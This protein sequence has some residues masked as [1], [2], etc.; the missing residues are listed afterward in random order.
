MTLGSTSLEPGVGSNSSSITTGTQT[1]FLTQNRS[2]QT[3]Q[4][5]GE[6]ELLQGFTPFKQTTDSAEIDFDPELSGAAKLG[7]SVSD[8][9][10]LVWLVNFFKSWKNQ[11]V[12]PRLRFKK[13]IVN[14]F[15][16]GR[17][18]ELEKRYVVL[19]PHKL[20]TFLEPV[21]HLPAGYG[22]GIRA[23][24]KGFVVYVRYAS[25][26]V[27]TRLTPR[28]RKRLSD[29][30]ERNRGAR[31]KVLRLR[32]Q[33]YRKAAITHA[34]IYYWLFRGD[35][36]V[37]YLY[38]GRS[39]GLKANN[40][41]IDASTGSRRHQEWV[42]LLQDFRANLLSEAA[43]SGFSER[44][45]TV[46]CPLLPRI[47][48]GDFDIYDTHIIETFNDTAPV[49]EVVARETFFIHEFVRTGKIKGLTMAE[50]TEGFVQEGLPVVL[51][52]QNQ[53]PSG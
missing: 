53:L 41:R 17:L 48:Q 13:P 8:F 21:T 34:G 22:P 18:C 40:R 33:D 29:I 3:D 51:L 42:D 15:E 39:A 11:S 16:L 6:T 10:G 25:R 30:R 23:A 31:G 38:I 2:T 26:P 9:I 7:L 37:F 44:L 46:I 1:G 24:P 35:N 32:P 5:V 49:P 14:A 28:E 27:R 12:V 36:G 20:P 50:L 47:L 43:L 52:N 19:S 4:V 45:Y